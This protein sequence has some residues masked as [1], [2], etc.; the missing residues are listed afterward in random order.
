MIV[1]ALLP[2]LLL[3]RLRAALG[4]QETIIAATSV[5]DDEGIAP[6]LQRGDIDLVVLDPGDRRL[7]HRTHTLTALLARYAAVPVLLYT[8]LTTTSIAF[9]AELLPGG[10]R[11]LLIAGVEDQPGATRALAV[12]MTMDAL[13]QRFLA[14][15]DR[16]LGEL[17]T[18]V[19]RAIHALF[20]SPRRFQSV[21]D[22]ALASAVTRRHLERVTRRVGFASCRELLI[23]ARTLAA[24]RLLQH[25]HRSLG[26]VAARLDVHPRVLGR[27]VRTLLGASSTFDLARLSADALL[28]ACTCALCRR[29]A[30]S[31][32]LT[33]TRVRRARSATYDDR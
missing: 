22:I 16:Q 25:E 23:I 5:E 3:G 17:P 31:S 27:Q 28:S 8:P 13:A 18:S 29:P 7:E 1:V 10:T 15:V 6:A 12:R 4:A 24:F 33:Q 14:S 20:A 26:Q 19:V 30:G 21:E 32:H 9:A 2:D 11:R